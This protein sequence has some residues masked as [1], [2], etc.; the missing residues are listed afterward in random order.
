MAYKMK[1][2]SGFKSPAKVSD[3]DL[4]GLQSKLNKSELDFKEPGWAKVAG[5]AHKAAKGPI[6]K[7]MDKKGGAE[8]EKSTSV[9]DVQGTAG[10]K[11]FKEDYKIGDYGADTQKG[12]IT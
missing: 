12:M 10:S 1:G 3:S 4:L 7:M 5:A 8:P 6:G 2:F 9:S 11:L